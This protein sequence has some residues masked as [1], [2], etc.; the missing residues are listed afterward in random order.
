MAFDLCRSFILSGFTWLVDSYHALLALAQWIRTGSDPALRSLAVRAYR[1]SHFAIGSHVI[2]DCGH[3]L[4]PAVVEAFWY[5]FLSPAAT[6]ISLSPFDSDCSISFIITSSS[7]LADC[8]CSGM[9]CTES[10]SLRRQ[11]VPST[12]RGPSGWAPRVSRGVTSLN[13]S[14]RAYR[15]VP[16]DLRAAGCMLEREFDGLENRR[17]RA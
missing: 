15:Q 14:R 12:D 11:S 8:T 3:V 17:G 5:A 2:V 1:P 4:K 13:K 9:A 16:R 6:P 7:P 10:H